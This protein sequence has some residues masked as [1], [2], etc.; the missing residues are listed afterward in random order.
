MVTDRLGSLGDPPTRLRIEL[1]RFQL[2]GIDTGWKVVSARR[3]LPKAKEETSKGKSSPLTS[4][5]LETSVPEQIPQSPGEIPS[6]S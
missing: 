3:V 4:P 5:E 1:V 2:E 6:G